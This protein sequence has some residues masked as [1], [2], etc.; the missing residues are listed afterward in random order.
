MSDE[1]RV[2][3]T[4]AIQV[5]RLTSGSFLGDGTVAGDSNATHKEH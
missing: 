3:E 4:R 5:L 1:R 2:V